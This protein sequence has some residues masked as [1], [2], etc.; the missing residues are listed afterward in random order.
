MK[1][2][3]LVDQTRNYTVN[4]QPAF[5]VTYVNEKSADRI[6]IIASDIIVS[7]HI[8]QSMEIIKMKNIN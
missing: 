2:S 8:A 4:V 6:Q 7:V 1:T 5:I 3:T